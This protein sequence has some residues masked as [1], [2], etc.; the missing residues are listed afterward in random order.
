MMCQLL[1][2]QIGLHEVLGA[3]CHALLERREHG[4]AIQCAGRHVAQ[5]CQEPHVALAQRFGA[6]N[7]QHP[8]RRIA[9]QEGNTGRRHG[10]L[11]ELSAHNQ[12]AAANIVTD[13]WLARRQYET[14]N[15]LVDPLH[16]PGRRR[17]LSAAKINTQQPAFEVGTGN[18]RRIRLKRLAHCRQYDLLG[19]HL[20]KHFAQ[21]S[22]SRSQQFQLAFP[23]HAFAD[24]DDNADIAGD[25]ALRI[26]KGM[27]TVRYPTNCVVA[28]QDAILENIFVYISRQEGVELLLEVFGI[29]R[30]QAI[31]P[32]HIT[33]HQLDR[34][35]AKLFDVLRDVLDWEIRSGPP[36][37]DDRATVI[38]D[39]F[40]VTCLFKCL[41]Q[42]LL[43]IYVHEPSKSRL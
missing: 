1:Q 3:L 37:H 42:A 28:V 13:I 20:G 39:R 7:C 33:G 27:R 15:S 25:L 32:V 41:G 10:T 5:R 14:G 34:I 16:V 31:G 43:K 2:A 17:P 35:K 21:R 8:Y 12:R 9:A 18:C 26:P 11:Y 40:E 38:Y 24:V 19:L 6:A 29:I 36:A 22:R 30:M 4:D 23:L